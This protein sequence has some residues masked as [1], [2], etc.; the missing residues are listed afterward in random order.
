MTQTTL[1][2]A[3]VLR[4]AASVCPLD[5]PDTCSL[6]VT[7]T[8]GQIT[9]VRGSR[10]NPYT[11]GVI[12]DKVAR[13]YPQFVHGP[14]RLRQPLERVGPRGSGR[15]APISWTE[16][17]DRVHAGLQAAIDAHGPQSV[18]PLNYAGPHGQISGGSMDRRFFHRL[19]ATL[20]DRGPLCGIV[21]GTAYTSLFGTAP[22]MPPE[23][24]RD[25]D[26]VA[27]WGNN[28]TVSNLHLTRVIKAARENGATLVVIDP[29]RT[30]I[31]EQAHL[32]VQIRPGTD[33]VLALALAAELERR[34]AFDRAFLETWV[35]GLDAYMDEA[36]RHPI[37]E[38]LTVCGITR[39]SFDRL[40]DLYAGAR[41]LA[42]SVG[43][44]ME[45]GH[46][47]GSAIRA[48][49]ALN[50]LTG[51]LGRPGAG[52]FARP[53]LAFPTT[54]AKLQRPDLVPPGTRTF[55]IV[56]V[57]RLLLDQTLAPPIKAVFI[58]N[59]NPVCTHP[60]QNR[61]RRALSRDDLF[62]VGCDVVMTDSMAYADVILPA[63]SHFEFDDVYTAYGQSYLQR[64]AP[65]IAPVGESL[66]NT[67]IFR[68]LA[69]RFG[70][71]EPA[72]RDSD[73]ALMDAALDPADPRL[74]GVRP[75]QLPLDRALLMNTPAGEPVMICNTVKPGTPSGKITLYSQDLQA[76]FGYGVPR[77]E[78][79]PAEAPLMLIS[80]SS[81]RRTNAT[82]GSDPVSQG[83]ER[84]ELHP[85]DA[86]V[87]GIA[88][89]AR[90]RVWNRLGEVTLVARVTDAVRAGVAYSSKGTWL[91]TS[92]TGQT[93]NALIDADRRTDIMS[94]ACYN[95]T[96][97]DVA[98]AR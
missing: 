15:Y 32:Y 33:V 58:Y 18:L 74:G 46:S 49:M 87:R 14:A 57:G 89:G 77:Y 39:E 66:P 2:T 37:D 86:A 25:A 91:S 30:K 61:M 27:V 72:F 50:V 16:A 84:I 35:E 80:P 88:D 9:Q 23:Q 94:G 75:S 92:D 43:N 62:V 95:D 53:G 97:V 63:S 44:G 28:V 11:A 93:V 29:R 6:S 81:S 40:A 42:L 10:A 21:R 51:Q 68:R 69:A 41:R 17:L 19:G 48:I 76:R 47:G 55:N 83:P 31:A 7:V 65:V 26:V 22:G 64:A 54:G 98:L 3:P 8:D 82:F 20:L 56:D 34:G 70:F 85:D 96:F 5:C 90:V 79:V 71:D 52:V 78:P 59:H 73:E 45:R 4:A 38:A 67:E 12:C 1:N 60:D 36:R 24:M 13:Y